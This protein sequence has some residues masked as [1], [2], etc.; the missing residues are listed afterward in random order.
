MSFVSVVARENFVTVMSDGR[1]QNND[2]IVREDYQ[3]FVQ[4]TPDLFFA[5][6]G[7]QPVGEGILK[8]LENNGCYELFKTLN[9]SLVNMI[10]RTTIEAVN[11]SNKFK[12]LVAYGGRNTNG[13]I[14]VFYANS[15]DMQ[16]GH[17]LP[18]GDAINVICLGNGIGTGAL[19]EQLLFQTGSTT[20]QQILSAQEMMN[21]YV[22]THDPSVNTTTFQMI[23]EKGRTDLAHS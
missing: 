15:I 18:K 6:T 23:I 8:A 17:Y 9:F 20:P 3:K 12:L 1:V 7:H 4:I 2:E 11:Q 10:I 22:V 5:Y 14:E 21:N 16:S 13:E 19:L